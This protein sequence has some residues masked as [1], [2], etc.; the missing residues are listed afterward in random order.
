MKNLLIVNFARPL[1]E[2]LGTMSAAYLIAQGLNSD[3]VAQLVNA[4]FAAVLIGID[5]VIS[6]TNREADKRGR[7]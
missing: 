1:L 4:V 7:L 6:A 3:L 5:L 2:R